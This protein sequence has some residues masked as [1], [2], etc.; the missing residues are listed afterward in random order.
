V[1][2]KKP[3]DSRTRV[4]YKA[5]KDQRIVAKVVYQWLKTT[6]HVS[7]HSKFAC[8]RSWREG[9]LFLLIDV[10]ALKY[11]NSIKRPEGDLFMKKYVAKYLGVI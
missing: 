11:V 4:S 1:K 7:I 2:T 3:H 9:T 5:C 8:L 10:V 6:T